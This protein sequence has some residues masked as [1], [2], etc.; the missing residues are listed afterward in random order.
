VDLA[1]LSAGTDVAAAIAR[2]LGINL[3]A[4]GDRVG[5]LVARLSTVSM[6]LVLDNAEHLIDETGRVAQRLV[7]ST[8]AIA[9]LFTS[10][11]PLGLEGEHLVRLGPLPVDDA[12]A[13]LAQRIGVQRTG[14]EGAAESMGMG[15]TDDAGEPGGEAEGVANQHGAGERRHVDEG[16]TVWDATHARTAA[17]ICQRLDGNPLAI[18]LAAARVHA[19]GLDGLE[20]RLPQRLTLLAPGE[21]ARATRRNALA[22]ALSWS[23]ELLSDRERAVLRRL[24]VFPASFSLQGAALALADDLLPAGRVIDAILALVDR[25]LIA[26]EPVV[27][28]RLRLMET[29]RLFALEQ[30]AV[31]GETAA[32]RVRWCAGVRWLFDEAYEEHWRAPQATWRARYEPELTT[33]WPALETA[34]QAC[35]DEAVA[36]FASSWP[37]WMMAEAQDRARAIAPRLVPLVEAHGDPQVRAR[38][39]EAMSRGHALDHPSVARDASRRA[40]ALYRA[41]GDAR[42][43]YLAEVELAFNWRVDGPQAREALERAKAL[44]DPDWPALVLERGW[45]TVAMV[46]T[47][48]GEHEAARHAFEA[49]VEVCRRDGH[50]VGILRGLVNLADLARVEGRLAQAVAQGE[51]LRTQLASAPATGLLGTALTNLVGALLAMD[52]IER[53]QAVSEECARRMGPLLFDACVWTS[54]DTLGLLHLKRGQVENAA[55]L[56]GAADR[57][58]RAHGQDARQPNEAVDQQLLDAG[59]KAALG[60]ERRQQFREEGERMDDVRALCLAFGLSAKV[61]RAV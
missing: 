29:M 2:T 12:V 1:A 44:E 34:I 17:R 26:V 6:L 33:L 37:V 20:A 13:L 57:A 47:T 40:A 48:A 15:P 53:A 38:F 3:P 22:A 52:Q 61:A 25:S 54:L 5:T 27:P 18:Q 36:L 32:M 56:A 7:Q 39:W 19:L 35:P 4:G 9:V 43:E 51:A 16:L 14:A 28:R 55:R 24:G 45:T 23:C 49:A 60:E 11:Q 31:A 30:M 58:F 59:L 10:Q 8:P 41:L 21:P 42:G 46:H 50:E